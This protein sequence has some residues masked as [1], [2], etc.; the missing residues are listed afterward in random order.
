MG[1][2]AEIQREMMKIKNE[3]EKT[4]LIHKEM[5]EN[6]RH[7]HILEEIEAMKKA[8]ITSFVRQVTEK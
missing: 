7:R 1:S 2:D 8:K 5:I 4:R 3:Q 6:L